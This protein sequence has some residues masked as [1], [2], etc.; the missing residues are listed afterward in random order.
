MKTL[1]KTHMYAN[2]KSDRE[3]VTSFITNRLNEFK[4]KNFKYKKDYSNW[5]WTID[6]QKD[7]EFTKRIY[8]N[9]KDNPLICFEKI[10]EYINA[11]PELP[12]I[13]EG[14]VRMEGYLKSLRED[15]NE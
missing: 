6:K 9:F 2:L 12:K 14:T 10:I 7:L 15:N 11:N 13:N 4:I 1:E 3:H 5:R 8:E